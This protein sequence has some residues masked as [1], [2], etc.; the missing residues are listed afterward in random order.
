[1]AEGL[2]L[3]REPLVRGRNGGGREIERAL[4]LALSKSVRDSKFSVGVETVLEHVTAHGSASESAL[5]IG[6][7]LQW[8]PTKTVHVDFVPLFGA[9]ADAPRSQ[10]F[11]VLGGNLRQGE[12][13]V[14]SGEP[15]SSKSR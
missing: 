10:I 4:T 5:L 2:A 8:R 3:G 13:G 14:D 6:P 7:S 12:K 11:V 9:T 1:M 15:V